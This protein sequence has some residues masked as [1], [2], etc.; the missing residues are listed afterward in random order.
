M[1]KTAEA[2]LPA[3]L[4]MGLGWLLRRVGLFTEELVSGL[5]RVAFLAIFPIFLIQKIGSQPLGEVFNGALISGTLISY[6]LIWLIVFALVKLKGDVDPQRAGVIVQGAFR[7]NTAVL[8]LAILSGAWGDAVFGPGG[9][10]LGA[11][12]PFLNVFSVL[13][14]LLPHRDRGGLKGFGRMALAVASN[15]FIIGAL[16]GTARSASGIK[17]PVVI[18]SA[19]ELLSDM[20][21]PV[22]LLCVGGNLRLEKLRSDLGATLP[23]SFIKL[24]FMP[25]LTWAVLGGI[26]HLSGMVLAIGV[27][28]AAAPTAMVSFIM[29]DQMKGDS[30]LAA[31]ILVMTSLFSIITM[32]LWLAALFRWG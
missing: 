22:M 20:A 5:N 4:I 1:I 8:G 2:V 9:M 29:A 3:F 10:L 21:I 23:T 28:F 12:V 6:C 13:A 26:F 17:P 31:S 32:S 16:L 11:V 27:I 18:D 30:D 25:A 24:I 15:P 7:P 19:F 14:L